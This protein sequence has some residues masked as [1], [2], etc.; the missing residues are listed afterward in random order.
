MRA[1]CE[2]KKTKTK[3][4]EYLYS[5]NIINKYIIFNLIVRI[6]LLYECILC[7]YGDWPLRNVF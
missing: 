4:V 1:N 5:V 3:T 2:E 6:M 7:N